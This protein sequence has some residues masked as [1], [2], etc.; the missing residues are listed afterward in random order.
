MEKKYIWISFVDT[1]DNNGNQGVVVIEDKNYQDAL[2]YAIDNNL[3][4]EKYNNIAMFTVSEPEIEPNRLHTP[5]EMADLGYKTFR[6][7]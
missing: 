3:T 1:D 6:Q 4:P 2:K 7:T 5:Q